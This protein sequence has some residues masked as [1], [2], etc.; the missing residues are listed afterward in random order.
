MIFAFVF[1]KRINLRTC[2]FLFGCFITV[3]ATGT[4]YECAKTFGY[5]LQH[6]AFVT[7]SLP[8]KGQE[9]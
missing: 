4:Q 5:T 7:A 3:E 1:R 2:D 6:E 8:F 9:K